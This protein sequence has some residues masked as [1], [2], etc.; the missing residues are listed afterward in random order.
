MLF[1]RRKIVYADDNY[2]SIGTLFLLRAPTLMLGAFLG[3]LLSLVTSR[4][5]EVLAQNVQ[6]AFFLP[7]IVYIAAA[8]GTQTE[9]IYSSNLKVGHA[10]FHRYLLKESALG[11]L[12]GCFFALF[13]YAV[14]FFWLHNQ[15][16]AIAVGVASAL[17]ILVAPV[18]ALIVTHIFQYLGKDPAIGSGPITT[19]IQ[20][21]TSVIIYGIVTSLILL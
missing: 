7:F 18:L 16:L 4:F 13:S 12:F 6:V 11:F 14:C 15:R 19:I 5:E 10:K 8:I 2:E 21:V 3:V 17:A 20:D 1:H 9:S